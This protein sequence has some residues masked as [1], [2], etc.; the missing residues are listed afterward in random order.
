MNPA[1]L[2]SSFSTFESWTAFGINVTG[3]FQ[4]VAGQTVNINFVAD[5]DVPWAEVHHG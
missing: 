2:T 3:A 1:D 5:I 4:A